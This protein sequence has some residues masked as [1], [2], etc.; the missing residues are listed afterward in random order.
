MSGKIRLAPLSG[1]SVTDSAPFTTRIAAALLILMGSLVG[2]TQTK[3]EEPAV[4]ISIDNFTFAPA[5]ITIP[6][7]TVVKWV[8]RDDIPHTI[9][10]KS[11]SFRSKALDTDDT[12]THQFNDVGEINYFCSLHPRM[13]GK[14]IVKAKES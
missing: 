5:E 11:L 10:E 12:F 3:T 8:N 13:T 9:V 4:E 2:P 14:I 1:A 6:A 7:G